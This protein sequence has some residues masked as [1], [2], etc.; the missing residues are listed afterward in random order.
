MSEKW[1]TR[2]MGLKKIPLE[3]FEEIPQTQSTDASPNKSEVWFCDL[4]LSDEEEF[5][6]AYL[7][8]E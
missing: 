4:Q 1:P 8:T 2:D 3:S 7:L 6:E 5:P